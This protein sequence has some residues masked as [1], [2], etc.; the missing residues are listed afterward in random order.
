MDTT[1][2]ARKVVLTVFMNPVVAALAQR[3]GLRL[4]ANRFIAGTR[5]TEAIQ[6]VQSLNG[7]GIKATL[8][9]L[10]E[11]VFQPAEAAATVAAYL[12]LLDAIRAAGVDSNVS[13]KLTAMGLAFDPGL[14]LR[15]VE[16]IVRR[17]AQYGNFV[18]IDME[19]TP[20]TDQTLQI[21]RELRRQ[22]LENVGVVIQ[23]YL[24]RSERDLEELAPL[25]ANVRLVKGAYKEP[26]HLAF[27]KMAEVNANFKRLIRKRLESGLY[28]AVATHDEEAI[29]FTKQVV[30]EIGVPRDR[31]EFQML[32]GV[33]MQLQEE[34][35]RE[36]YRVR[37]YV[38][39]GTHW[40]PYFVR[41][42]AERPANV[43]FV[44]R[45]LF[46]A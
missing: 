29:A 8:D 1:L 4:G 45:N 40:Y 21:Y 9:F 28:T 25:G 11:S 24:F 39:Y 6:A 22:G 34:L 43:G 44:L 26:A 2:I 42:L 16:Q 10:G 17:A 19:D 7:K 3:Y 23:A 41:R 20:Y 5:L 35:A 12:E 31:F 18:R 27:E 46:R 30:R 14:A 37:C 36:G 32:Y 33:R 15:N 38:P 13:L